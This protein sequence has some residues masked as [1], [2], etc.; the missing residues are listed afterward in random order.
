MHP[1]RAWLDAFKVGGRLPLRAPGSA[2]ERRH[3]VE[4]R[5]EQETLGPRD[6]YA[7]WCSSRAKA[8][9]IPRSAVG[10]T[11]RSAA[12]ALRACARLAL[13]P[14]PTGRI[15]CE[16]TAGRCRARRRISR[17]LHCNSRSRWWLRKVPV[18]I[19]VWST[20]LSSRLA[21]LNLTRAADV[22]HRR[23]KRSRPKAGA[24]A[25]RRR[26]G[27]PRRADGRSQESARLARMNTTPHRNHQPRLLL[28]GPVFNSMSPLEC[29]AWS[30]KREPS[31][32]LERVEP[33]ADGMHC[34]GVDVNRVGLG[35]L[36]LDPRAGAD[37][38]LSVTG[39][40]RAHVRRCPF[41]LCRRP[42]CRSSLRV[43]RG[44]R[45]DRRRPRQH[46]HPGRLSLPSIWPNHS[47]KVRLVFARCG[48]R[49]PIS[50]KGIT[51]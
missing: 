16:A 19:G 17:L 32:D 47:S 25:Q 36:V 29:A 27:T 37:L 9:K 46:R 30:A 39:E 44:S 1:V 6:S 51:E 21:T 13:A 41:R 38:D 48:P 50:K 5:P 28:F 14:R 15:G 4:Y 26:G 12:A 2:F 40:V 45:C 22:S 49:R 23:R 43:L 34:G 24:S 8:R 10:S 11:R 7:A 3:A 18:L 33:R 42:L 35:Q 20:R 31:A